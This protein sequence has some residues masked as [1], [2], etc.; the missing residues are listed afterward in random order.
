MLSVVDRGGMRATMR[1]H[2]VESDAGEKS[3]LR[4]LKSAHVA[5]P[6]RGDVADASPLPRHGLR[7]EAAPPHLETGA[8]PNARLAVEA[9]SPISATSPRHDATTQGV[10]PR[11][12]P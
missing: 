1:G 9:A 5:S 4:I 7:R 2:P 8:C 3:P 12:P 10:A 6:R 11:R